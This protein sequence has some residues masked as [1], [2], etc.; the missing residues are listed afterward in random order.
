LIASGVGQA[1][2]QTQQGQTL[3]R[4]DT[5]FTAL[6]TAELLVNLGSHPLRSFFKDG[7]CHLDWS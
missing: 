1:G 6:F 2:S 4:L 3:D 7:C 5:A